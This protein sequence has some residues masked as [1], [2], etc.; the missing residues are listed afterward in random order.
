MGENYSSPWG[1]G[2]SSFPIKKKAITSDWGVDWTVAVDFGSMSSILTECQLGVGWH[3]LQ[4]CAFPINQSLSVLTLLG[5]RNKGSGR[6][7]SQREGKEVP[8]GCV[9]AEEKHLLVVT[10]CLH[11][12]KTLGGVTFNQ[13]WTPDMMNIKESCEHVDVGELLCSQ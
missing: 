10:T 1:V 11:F 3:A 4:N 6:R 9:R 2:E 8:T 13:G 12:S 5:G 7:P